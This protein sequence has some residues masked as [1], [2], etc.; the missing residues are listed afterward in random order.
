MN[1]AIELSEFDID[2]ALQNTIKGQVL[3]DFVAEFTGFPAESEYA[4]PVKP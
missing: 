3:P 2:Y 1:W 4:P